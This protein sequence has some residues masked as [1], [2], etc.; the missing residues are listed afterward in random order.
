MVSLIFV[1]VILVIFIPISIYTLC[2]RIALRAALERQ[3]IIQHYEGVSPVQ[4]YN[5]VPYMVSAQPYNPHNLPYQAYTPAV[6]AFN[7]PVQ[8]FNPPVLPTI[9]PK[10][11]ERNT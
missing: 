1:G 3:P 8:A 4:A 5:T 7:P 9:D 10:A 6:Q 11:Q 2:R